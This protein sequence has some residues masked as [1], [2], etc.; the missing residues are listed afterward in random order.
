[1]EKIKYIHQEWVHNTRS[2]EII[3]PYI[4]DM[5]EVSSVLDVGCGLG[6]WLNA[7]LKNDVV[8]LFGID[9]EYVDKTLLQKY[10]SVDQFKAVDLEKRF[11]L[12]RKFDLAISLEV[13]EHLEETA[14]CD[15][16]ESLCRHSDIILFSAAIPG[17]GG[18]NHINEQWPDYWAKKF[19]KHNFVFLDIIRPLIWDNKDIDFWYRQNIFLVVKNSHPLAQKYPE[20]YTSLVHPVLF[21]RIQANYLKRI[22][23]LESQ[24]KVHPLKRWLKNLF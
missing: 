9:G 3:V 13:G 8:N 4:I 23:H 24:L 10:I 7:F 20:S 17:Q 2:S 14:S 5:I 6:T 18:Q 19:A 1:L 21:E 11:D 12:G 16:V 22:K 15:F